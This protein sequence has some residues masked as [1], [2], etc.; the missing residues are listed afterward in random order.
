MLAALEAAGSRM[1]VGITAGW[2]EKDGRVVPFPAKFPEAAAIIRE[3]A[4]RRLLE[5]ANHGY[6][7]CVLEDRLF[8]P[9]LF[10]GN[11]QYHR[12]F[13]DWLPE[14]THREHLSRAQG[15]LEQFFASPVLTLIPPGNVFSPKTLRA[16]VKLGLRYLCLRDA[17]RGGPLEGL[18]AVEDARVVPL[19]DRDLVLGGLE[20]FRRLVAD[21]SRAPFVTVREVGERLERAAR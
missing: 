5:V 7:H 17:G 18:T 20:P 10:S 15:I 16:A 4:R 11:R 13:H 9:R 3:G 2:V 12:E 6:T 8:R 1:T 14:E 21:S 19:H